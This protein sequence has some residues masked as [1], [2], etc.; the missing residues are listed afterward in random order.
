MSNCNCRKPKKDHND[1]AISNIVAYGDYLEQKGK[2]ISNI[3]IDE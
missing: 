1:E 3:P 2:T